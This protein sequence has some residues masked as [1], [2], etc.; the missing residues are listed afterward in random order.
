MTHPF[1]SL[2]TIRSKTE[3]AP[4][5]KVWDRA[6]SSKSLRDYE[7]RVAKYT[8]QLLAQ[9]EARIGTPVNMTNWISFYGFDVMGDLAFGKSFDMLRSGEVDYYI[10]VMQDFLK[11]RAAFGR[12]PWAFRILQVTALL[13]A[14]FNRFRKWME[15]Q[16]KWRMDVSKLSSVVLCP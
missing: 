3:H 10:G 13:N 9:L 11:V 12:I 16:V 8:S 7:P 1:L 5:R 6:F 14:S 4:V 15:Q 2:Q